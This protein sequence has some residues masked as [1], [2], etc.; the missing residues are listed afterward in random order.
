VSSSIE[1]VTPRDRLDKV[2]LH[3]L[4]NQHMK[5]VLLL[6][7]TITMTLTSCG[8]STPSTDPVESPPIS[9]VGQPDF[10]VGDASTFS[11]LP[12][13]SRE[14]YTGGEWFLA[15]DSGSL[16]CGRFESAEAVGTG[17]LET[18]EFGVNFTTTD[19]R[20]F[21]IDGIGR[22]YGLPGR[23]EIWNAAKEDADLVASTKFERNLEAAGNVI[24]K[25]QYPDEYSE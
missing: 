24:C 3:Q 9:N 12:R 20:T 2:K 7:L 22:D 10:L 15:V 8:S 6:M 13:I 19:G 11:N 4:L 5:N 21:S 18:V 1:C 23:E 14:T 16:E 17:T 25:T